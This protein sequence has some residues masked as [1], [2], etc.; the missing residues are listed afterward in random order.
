MEHRSI[1]TNEARRIAAARV[2]ARIKLEQKLPGYNHRKRKSKAK[3]FKTIEKPPWNDRFFTADTSNKEAN[4]CETKDL[5]KN[6]KIGS[7][8]ASRATNNEWENV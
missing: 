4:S 7:N 3:Q 6:K 1:D 5:S 2:K 8:V